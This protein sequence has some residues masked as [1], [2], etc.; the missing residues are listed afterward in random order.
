[1]AS[2]DINEEEN[3]PRIA[4][5]NF[6]EI[7][8]KKEFWKLPCGLRGERKT[9]PIFLPKLNAVVGNPPYVRQELIPR[10]ADKPKADSAKEDLFELCKNLWGIELTGRSDLH[11][12]FWPA[13]AAFLKE[14]GWFGFLV[15]S[16]WL[17]V[18]YGFALQEWILNNFK[19]H[20]ILESNAEPWFE[21]ARVKTCA[22][23]LQRCDDPEERFKHL[24]K[25]VRLDAPLAD[26]L[27]ERPDEN[28]RQTAA[29][30]FRD[31][32]ARC[33]ED[34]ARDQFRIVVVPQKK[35][36][37]D[38]LR[39]GKLFALQK[40]RDSSEGVRQSGGGDDE[41]ENGIYD[42]A[43][44]GVLH[45]GGSIGYG[46]KYGGGKW[47]KYLRAP[48][49]YFRIMERYASRFVPLGEIATV[50]RGITSGCD[51]FFMPRD[52]SQSFLDKYSKQEWN[53][54]PLHTHCKRAEIESGKVKLIKTGSGDE[55]VHPI[56]AE[57]LAPEVHSLMNVNRPVIR[58]GE[59][60]RLVL[61]VSKPLGKLEGTYI[62]KYIRY[63]EQTTFASAK[64]KAVPVAQRTSC[65]GRNL[66]YDLTGSTPGAFFWPMAQQYRH[67]IPANLEKLICNHNLFDVHPRDLDAQAIIILTAVAN[68]TLVAN[69]KT[70]YGRYAGTEGNLKTEVVDVNLLE[71]PDPRN[72]SEAVAKKLRDAFEQLC[73]RDT[74]SLVEAAFVECRS[75][76]RAKKLA[77]TPI[78]LPEELKQPDRR[79]LDLA[80]FELLGVSEASECEK[81]L[82]EL[83]WETANHFRQIRL[84]EIQKQEQRAKSEG[85]EFRTDELAADIWDSLPPDDRQPFAA[86][87]ASQV[88][89]GL[90]FSIP[91]SDGC[92]LMDTSDFL[93]AN[94]VFFSFSGAL[95]KEAHKLALPSRAHAE[96]AYFAWQHKI[97]GD[98]MLPKTE[99]DASSLHAAAASRV[100]AIIAKADGLARSRT[101]DERKAMD[102][103]RLIVSWMINGKPDNNWDKNRDL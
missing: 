97:F 3:Y 51:A 66:W 75:H 15:S 80:V 60:D 40:Q 54:A 5:R 48:N 33:K 93:D 95:K 88:A 23:I 62:Q 34:K 68:S 64:S 20:A 89:D 4:R 6:F 27:G 55:T 100:K 21:D 69:F 50:R 32:I 16:S 82:G 99:K 1:L 73:C 2:R 30:K 47:G 79:A 77:A 71:I 41:E 38:G 52:V 19:I 83:Y 94:S 8:E 35:L 59:L 96:L 9:E 98:L 12:Y 86:W 57:Y 36:W 90:P 26:I 45:D 81:L 61:L 10:R 53:N 18:E 13:S 101:G 76:E 24:V 92:R 49:F 58:V 67:V 43:G 31:I 11:C 44:N 29:E 63:G 87:L 85:R 28:S 17:D 22:V 46:P 84:V 65:A 102:L 42:E 37:D 25:F 103:S 14:N 91:E 74:G 70:F 78:E 72:A 56:E 7:R 39:A